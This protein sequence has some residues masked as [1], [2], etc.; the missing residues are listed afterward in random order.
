MTVITLEELKKMTLISQDAYSVGDVQDVRYDASTWDVEGLKVRCTKDVSNLIGAGS[1]K[2]M[3]LVKP[4]AFE[5][6]DV[7]L[8]PDT[9]EGARSYIRADSDALPSVGNLIGKKVYSHDQQIVGTVDS[10]NVD[11]GSWQVHSFV[12]KLDKTAHELLGVKKGF[13]FLSKSVSGITVG[14]VATV[15]EMI[16]LNLTMDQVKEI[17]TLD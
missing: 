2:S 16:S 17:V 15:S 13:G 8:M 5:M 11:L 10:V 1:S 6:H 3:I 4:P 12:I 9:V 14:H 7:I